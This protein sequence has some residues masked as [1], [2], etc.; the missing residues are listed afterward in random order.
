[1]AGEDLSALSVE[2]LLA[3]KQGGAAPAP[4]IPSDLSSLST[5]DLLA[6]KS[7]TKNN[8]WNAVDSAKNFG[9]GVIE[10]I[11]GLIG[12]GA[13]TMLQ[14]SSPATAYQSKL[15]GLMP[16][17]II[18][19]A[20][21]P[22]LAEEDPQYRYARTIGQFA[23]PAGEGSLL[24][25]GVQAVL[26]GAG[27]EGA[28]QL[29]GDTKIA[30]IVGAIA[31]GSIGSAAD[32]VASLLKRVFFGSSNDEIVGSAS[33][34]FGE[35]TGLT[36]KDLEAVNM[37]PKDALGALQ[38]TAERVGPAK[39]AG[40]AQLEKTLATT[41]DNANIYN[42][43]DAK[44]AAVRENIIN[45]ASDVKAVNEEGLNAALIDAADLTRGKMKDNASAF[46]K[47]FP[48]EEIIPIQT[49]MIDVGSTLASK[50]G[51]LAI[52]PKVQELADQIVGAES[53]TLSSG[54]L[55]DIRSDALTL[56]RDK[57]LTGFETKVLTNIEK[58]VDKAMETQ[59]SPKSY[60]QWKAATQAT[61]AMKETFKRGT[62]GGY[63]VGDQARVSNALDK[64]FKGDSQSVNELR[65]AI[66]ENPALMEEI[67]RGL[68][69]KIPRDAKKQLTPA[70]F[71]KF[72]DANES[73]LRN[74]LGEQHFDNFKRVGSDL[75]SQS[76]VQDSAFK[77]SKG[78]SVTGQKLTVAGAIQET[79]TDSIISGV[80][81]PFGKLVEAFKKGAGIKDQKAVEDLLFKASL[82]PTFA[83]TLAKAPTKQRIFDA[84]ETL[85]N[86][87]NNAQ[88]AGIFNTAKELTRNED[89]RTPLG[90]QLSKVLDEKSKENL[91]AKVLG[92]P[93]TDLTPRSEAMAV[94]PIVSQFEGGQKLSAYPPPAK[95]SG[96]T[97]GT[98]IDLGQ[99]SLSE[100]KEL[101]LPE[102]LLEKVSPYL[103]KKDS[104]ARE[105][106]K[107]NPLKLSQEEAD[108]LDSA[109]SNK[110]SSEVSAKYQ[111]A[112]GQD[113]SSLPEE[114][115][116]V[117]ESVAYNF[118]P[119]LDTKLPS[120]WKHVI[121]G[122]W[123]GMHDFL[124]NTRWKQPELSKRRYQ[125]AALL[126][127]LLDQVKV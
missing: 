13:D 97:V 27:A 50:K 43:L 70:G 79:V 59:L 69:D 58:N 53:G 41:G 72:I 81:G 112:T 38:T 7:S 48:R 1:M 88:A 20:S 66:G 35:A 11:T 111:K 45:A 100:L 87:K 15:Q 103:G 120:L 122:D 118:G 121:N 104:D 95:G 28:E 34:A 84:L 119:N 55:Q 99:R 51:G 65:A 105:Y 114:A 93:D 23:L 60:Q 19:K 117:L 16:S 73:G 21:S 101:D 12:M 127:P 116:T 40:V 61:A 115:R 77:A 14:M 39:A 29:T 62:A 92:N 25:Q 56:M 80:S 42:A 30:P 54:A 9:S 6:L 26:G 110:I 83:E 124:V 68:L 36:A 24:K 94:N 75:I 33:K 125:E 10:G 4:S 71:N 17:S 47:D 46:W 78:N 123:Q 108:A 90:K 2:D 109:V 49:A 91:A 89:N 113:L 106:L 96:V 3:L 82:D 18:Q 44:R 74:I 5:A 57:T 52:N 98:G 67:K 76:S 32:D 102:S 37:G 22:L 86:A 126:T 107:N 63:L 85:T 8:D 64:A 31:A